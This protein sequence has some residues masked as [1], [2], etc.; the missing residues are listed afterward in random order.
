MVL[1]VSILAASAIVELSARSPLETSTDVSLTARFFL[2][3]DCYPLA[4][5]AALLLVFWRFGV[6]QSLPL[7]VGRRSPGSFPLT[8]GLSAAAVVISGW[9]ASELFRGFNLSR[10]EIMAAFDAQILASGRL[11]GRIPE[12]WQGYQAALSPVFMLPI[13]EPFWISSYL[14]GNAALRAVTSLV[15]DPAWTSPLL[16]GM[17]VLCLAS[18]ARRL[19]PGQRGPQFIAL[20]LLVTSP[21]VLTTAMTSY[22]MTAH[23]AFN[24][25]WLALFLR[26]DL[27]GHLGAM[28]AGWV[29]T[30]LH[31]TVF[32][33]LFVAPFVIGLWWRGR[34]ELAIRYL[35]AYFL[36][37]GFWTLYWKLLL[38]SQRLSSPGSA[39]LGL[40]FF[41]VR[42]WWMLSD[43]SISG[44]HLML[45]NILRALSWQNIALL[46]LLPLSWR[47]IQRA[48]GIARELAAGVVLTCFAML[49]LLAYQGHGWGYRYIHG[50]LGN[51]SLLA[52]Y[53]WV[54]T[55][56]GVP[57]EDNR[58]W[59]GLGAATLATLLILLPWR[60]HQA[61]SFMS[62]Y[63]AAV[64]E[65]VSKRA[66]VV[67]VDWRGMQFGG[68]LVRNDPLL[69]GV[70]KILDY[71][72][73]SRDQIR[74]LCATYTVESFDWTDGV[75]LGIPKQS[76]FQPS[77]TASPLPVRDAL[78][79]IGCAPARASSAEITSH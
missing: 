30:G 41:L 76:A 10:D 22:A 59:T 21:Q 19:W 47:A 46:V 11:I 31:Q 3:Q 53:G 16:L 66:D 60:L 57:Q 50:L 33:P 29:A 62:P 69:R 18:V 56:R 24:L 55:T 17:A 72:Q 64:E 7:Q 35:L 5:V 39:D 8:L 38:A 61:V 71:T 48:E 6:P 36:I 58:A 44:L 26:N 70:P 54:C 28:V 12:Q 74:N 20:V 23:L 65:I 37:F 52:G 78:R 13:A 51:L 45:M 9:G 4:A 63:R 42:V 15:L 77:L 32:H 75:R 68:D 2:E 14:P 67:L 40:T 1:L 79:M 34:R 25:L 73:I 27:R 49:V 43:F